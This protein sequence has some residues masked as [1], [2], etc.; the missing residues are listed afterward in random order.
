M[1]IN[2]RLRTIIGLP[3]LGNLFEEP[4]LMNFHKSLISL[5]GRCLFI[6]PRPE[7]PEFVSEF[8]NYIPNFNDRL[9]I[10]PG[11]TGW[12]QVNGG[13]DFNSV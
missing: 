2:G 10:P 5:K 8:L 9:A 1:G 3:K 6:G 11:I 12:A 13:Y 7:R 4:E